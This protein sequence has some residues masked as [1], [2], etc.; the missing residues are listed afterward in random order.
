M[1][2]IKG[3]L[4]FASVAQD[5]SGIYLRV[6][7]EDGKVEVC[8]LSI[9]ESIGDINLILRPGMDAKTEL[10]KVANLLNGYKTMPDGSLDPIPGFKQKT[11]NLVSP[12]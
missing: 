11:I 1:S 7:R 4:I 6:G 8:F 5:A 3:K 12:S 9:G 2:Q 10:E